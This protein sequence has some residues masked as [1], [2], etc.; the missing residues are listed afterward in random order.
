[1]PELM[2]DS[3]TTVQATFKPQGNERLY[4][5]VLGTDQVE[6]QP[7][8]E[9]GEVIIGRSERCD[10]RIQDDSISRQ[11]ALLRIGTSLT[12]EDLGSS[13]GTAV[14]EQRLET[15]VPVEL[16]RGEVFTVGTVTLVVQQRSTPIRSRR[17]WS[18]DYF[19][20]RVREECARAE[21][22]GAGFALLRVRLEAEAE[23]AAVSE[24]LEAVLRDIDVTGQY[25]PREYEV[26][27]IDATVEE[28]RVVAERL[29]AQLARAG[30][31][32]RIG[33][34]CFP[35]DGR[36]ADKLIG[37]ARP[38]RASE[39]G[40]RQVVVRGANMQNL[41]RLA[42]RVAK[43][44]INVLILGETGVGKQVLAENIH[45]MSPRAGKPFLE[46]NCSAFSETL[47]ES[48]LFG[49][50]KG[51]FTGATSSKPGLLETADGGTVFLDEIGDMA[52]SLQAKLLRVIENRKVMRVG[53]LKPKPIDVRFVSATNRELESDVMRGTF[54]Q[55]LYFRIN[56]VTLSIPPLRER[57]DEIAGLAQAFLVEAAEPLG[58][59]PPRLS[60]EALDLLCG[61]SWPGNIRELRNVMER[62]VLLCLADEIT[63]EHLPVEKMRATFAT[64]V[65]DPAPAIRPGPA[66]T[67]PPGPGV[68]ESD[69]AKKQRILEA[70]MA[71]GGNN[72]EAAK[73]LGVSRRTLGKWLEAYNIPRPRKKKGKPKPARE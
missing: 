64:A 19:E 33:R 22:S 28:A 11:H 29:E 63:A 60:D 35:A 54:R 14:R 21:R 61:Y 15:N 67:P 62:A 49:Y 58:Q 41:Y 17:M 36:S 70:L 6:S 48:E 13:N 16:S 69:E 5:L 23:P 3:T 8:P 1:M 30:L 40:N 25:G 32:A 56:G 51:A 65:K 37:R 12:I 43:G 45:K 50:E 71:C 68:K 2:N 38:I 46:L 24:A 4:L 42:E 9:S 66:V 59:E 44:T 34:A 7:L 27:L 72:T 57:T 55:D 39:P 31:Q 20:G 18:H 52:L 10:V 73:L 26:L 47:L 53:G